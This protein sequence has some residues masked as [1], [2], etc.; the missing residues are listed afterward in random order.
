MRTTVLENKK[1]IFECVHFPLALSS[2]SRRRMKDVKK[3]MDC[4]L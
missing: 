4:S 3:K 1:T 2:V